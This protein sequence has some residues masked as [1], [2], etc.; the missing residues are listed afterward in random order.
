VLIPLEGLKSLQRGPKISPD[1]FSILFITTTTTSSSS[2]S[3]GFGYR[4]E[5]II[6]E[7]NPG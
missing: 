2:S 4:K 1:F 5:R 7:A 3:V 6:S